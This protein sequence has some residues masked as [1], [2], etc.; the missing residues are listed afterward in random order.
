M[1]GLNV[2]DMIFLPDSLTAFL[3]NKDIPSVFF[4]YIAF[5]KNDFTNGQFYAYKQSSN[6]NSGFWI[7]IK[8]SKDS[9][10][11]LKKIAL[12][13]GATFFMGLNGLC[14]VNDKIFIAEIGKE[15][16]HATLTNCYNSVSALHNN[17]FKI[18]E[19]VY[20]NPFGAIL[21]FDINSDKIYPLIFG[22][23]LTDY[24]ILSNPSSISYARFD[25]NDFL[26]INENILGP[27]K[28]RAPSHLYNKGK[29][30]NETWVLDLSE[31]NPDFDNLHRFLLAPEGYRIK[32]GNFDEDFKSY[33]FTLYPNNETSSESGKTST[34]SITGF[35]DKLVR[36]R[37]L[38][39]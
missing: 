13:E 10:P 18:N 25:N 28:G 35:K 17:Y 33:F 8:N 20:D 16:F 9:I 37:R 6:G 12:L 36:E 32:G 39:N 14:L 30:I 24:K 3:T 38:K 15:N 5:T 4:K 26:I 34:L 19:E 27:G 29:I 22:G 1:Y 23:N 11:D 2:G 21:G 7:P 31:K